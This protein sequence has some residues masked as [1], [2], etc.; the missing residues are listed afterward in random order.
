MLN[1]KYIVSNTQEVKTKLNT[2]GFDSSVIDE[3]VILAKRRT[4]V[5]TKIQSLESE[6][7]IIS[8]EIGILK[9]QGK[10]INGVLVKVSSIKKEIESI[11]GNVEEV[12]SKIRKHLLYI[13]NLPSNNTH[14]GASEVDNKVI[15]KCVIGRGE[16]KGVKPNYEIAKDL[17][18]VDFES[19][20][21]LSG[22]RFWSYK[23]EGSRLVRAL[24]NFMLDVHTKN[25]YI[26]WRLPV[27]VKSSMLEGT[28]QL[29]KF[30]DD[31]FKIENRDLYLIPTTEVPLTNI[32]NN[33]IINVDKPIQYTAFTTC[34]RAESGSGGKD[35][36][37]LI[38]SHQ[39]NKVELV[40]FVKPEE[41]EVE[42]HKTLKDARSILEMLELPYRVLEL[43]TGDIGFSAER[44][45][46]LEIWLPSEE[47]YR[48]TSSVSLFG[49]YQARRASIRYRTEDGN[50]Y[51]HT[52]NGS[53]LAI[54]RVVAAILEVYQNND[55]TI[56][57][58]EVLQKYMGIKKISK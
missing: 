33:E 17:D 38:R 22:S 11:K 10:D 26:E 28:G 35:M 4:E 2:R 48:E 29:P 34:F 24:E 18:I 53:A 37:G 41:S 30:G 40:K 27:L 39:F 16:V 32:H 9:S 23:G 44:T 5:L 57:V 7:N 56:D 15:E 47:R 12:N 42:F 31:L 6:R 45:I 52:I 3:I 50:K 51:P 19:A 21:K 36:K 1:L 13:P 49:D 54:D 14:V 55:G 46:D 43:C 25:G 58:P 20:V 8:K